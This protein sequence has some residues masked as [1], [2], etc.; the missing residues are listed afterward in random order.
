[1]GGEIEG[2]GKRDRDRCLVNGESVFPDQ[3]LWLMLY[4]CSDLSAS[5]TVEDPP[6][7]ENR[8]W[9]KRFKVMNYSRP[10]SFPMARSLQERH[11]LQNSMLRLPEQD[12][13]ADSWIQRWQRKD[14]QPVEEEGH[15]FPSLAAMAL[16]GKAITKFR[17]CKF[18][19]R[20][21]SLVWSNE[22]L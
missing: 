21:S 13:A 9:V 19:R 18:Q 11:H 6:G 22:D 16:V 2:E 12:S 5:C 15:A 8:S 20:G 1:M 4:P 3:R 10:N 14:S 17:P 7:E